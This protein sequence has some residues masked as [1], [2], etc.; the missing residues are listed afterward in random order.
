MQLLVGSVGV[1]LHIL[2]MV[3]FLPQP[4]YFQHSL[5]VMYFSPNFWPWV[6]VMVDICDPESINA[7]TFLSSIITFDS[8][9]FPINLNRGSG[10]WHVPPSS[11]STLPCLLQTSTWGVSPSVGM[12]FPHWP[13]LD[14]EACSVGGLGSDSPLEPLVVDLEPLQLLSV[15]GESASSLLPPQ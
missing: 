8:L 13:A 14:S 4:L 10:L 3:L 6:R 2:C 7:H 5:Q 1:N 12:E 9:G 15:V 11:S